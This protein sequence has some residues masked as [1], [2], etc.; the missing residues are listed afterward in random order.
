MKEFVKLNLSGVLGTEYC[1]WNTLCGITCCV[2]I[3]KYNSTISFPWSR[4]YA[5]SSRRNLSNA[6][7]SSSS[8]SIRFAFSSAILLTLAANCDR[9]CSCELG[10]FRLSFGLVTIFFFKRVLSGGASC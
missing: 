7:L 10:I 3:R 9:A 6:S 1:E 2:M 5:V 4:F 8:S